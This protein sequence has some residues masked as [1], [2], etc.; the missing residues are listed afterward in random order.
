[1]SY[2]IQVIVNDEMEIW[3]K[4]Q[5]KRIGLSASA[6]C[7]IALAQYKE[8]KEMMVNMPK[9]LEMLGT[10]IKLKENEENKKILQDA[11]WVEAHRNKKED[12]K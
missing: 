9:M 6:M 12:Q 11:D 1:M 7:N 4:E 10:A 2:K 3:V 8:Q 5:S